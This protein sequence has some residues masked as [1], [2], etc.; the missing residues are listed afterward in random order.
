[1]IKIILTVLIVLGSFSCFSNVKFGED[2]SRENL[3]DINQVLLKSE[4]FAGKEITIR[5]N[6]EKVCLKKGCW[7][8]LKSKKSTVRVTFKDYG[9]FVPS[10]FLGK[11]VVLKG[12]FDIKEETVARQKHLLEDEGRSKKEIAQIT[13]PQQ[14]YSF[15]SSGIELL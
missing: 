11:N 7:L 10:N 5:G 1:M 14:I 3:L 8:N 13:K 2:V 15:V 6:V 4:S 12:I 9:I